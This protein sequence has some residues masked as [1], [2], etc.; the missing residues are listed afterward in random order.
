MNLKRSY[1]LLLTLSVFSLA[2]AYCVEYILHLTA[3][4]LCIYQRFPYL[5]FIFISIISLTENNYKSYRQYLLAT[6]IG[7]ILLAGYHTGIERG[8][9]EISALCTPLVS[10]TDNISV[11]DFKKLL[12]SQEIALCNKPAL[13]IFGLSM[14]QWNLLLN[15]GLLIFFMRNNAKTIF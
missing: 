15:I 10:I 8:M 12:Y 5:I 13:V 14:T 6:I 2:I 11:N 3:C 4:P 7:A 9:F 1:L